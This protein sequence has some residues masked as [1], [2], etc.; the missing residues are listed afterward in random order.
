ML[1]EGDGFF[2]KAPW[3]LQVD[4]VP[5]VLDGSVN[6]MRDLSLHALRDLV[7]L[8]VLVPGEQERWC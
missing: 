5:G 8:V 3:I 2:Q 4:R 7:E 6:T 1:Q